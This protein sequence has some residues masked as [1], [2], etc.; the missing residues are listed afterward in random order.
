VSALSRNDL[1]GF[2]LSSP[3]RRQGPSGFQF[4]NFN[5]RASPKDAGFLPAQERRGWKQLFGASTAELGLGAENVYSR[6]Y[7]KCA[8]SPHADWL[9]AKSCSAYANTSLN[10]GK[11]SSNPALN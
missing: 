6:V 11:P 4:A 2:S 5:G 9:L 8:V 3:L 7:M 1:F 10:C